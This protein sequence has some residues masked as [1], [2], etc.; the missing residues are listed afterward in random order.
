MRVWTISQHRVCI[1]GL[2]VVYCLLFDRHG[3]LK[4]VTTQNAARSLDE[5]Q[6]KKN[7][8]TVRNVALFT[9]LGV[10]TIGLGLLVVGP[11]ISLSANVCDNFSQSIGWLSLAVSAVLLLSYAYVIIWANRRRS[12]DKERGESIQVAQRHQHQQGSNRA[13]IASPLDS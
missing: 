8:A 10:W 13:L 12:T 5:T 1:A 7:R 3:N 2:G 4:Y 9:N 11:F 6:L